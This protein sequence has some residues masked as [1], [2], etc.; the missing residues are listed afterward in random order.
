MKNE[1][2]YGKKLA[3]LIK[4][5]KKECTPA[6][7]FEGDLVG[8][9]V[10]AFLQWEATTKQATAAYE[11]LMTMM[12]DHNDLRVSYVHEVVALIGTRYPR[13]EDR[14]QRLRQALQE[15]YLRQRA[16]SLD[17]LKS[18]PLKQVRTYLDSLPGMTPYVAAQV[19]LLGFSGHAIPVDEALVSRLSEAE[20]IDPQASVEVVQSFL[21]RRIKSS[22]A[23]DSHLAMRAWV[24]ATRTRRATKPKASEKKTA[25]RKKTA[26]SSTKKSQ[27][28]T[29][30]KTVKKST[31]KTRDAS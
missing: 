10:M 29:N 7:A 26:S 2:H 30:K 25:T 28:T 5:I 23:L 24:N 11:R 22:E 20:V 6:T 3:S 18:R 15:I 12:V 27:T 8:H 19:T 21:E 9:L 14:A 31:R 16:V 13:A 17:K 1:S 4:Q